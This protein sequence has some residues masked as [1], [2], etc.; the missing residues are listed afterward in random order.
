MTIIV[1][2]RWQGSFTHQ[3]YSFYFVREVHKW[4]KQTTFGQKKKERYKKPLRVPGY[5]KG[6][7]NSF[8]NLFFFHA[9]FSFFPEFEDLQ[10]QLTPELAGA[11]VA[12][13][14][15]ATRLRV[16]GANNS[17]PH[18][19]RNKDNAPGAVSTLFL[20]LYFFSCVPPLTWLRHRRRPCAAVSEPRVHEEK[21]SDSSF[22][23]LGDLGDLGKS[24][25]CVRFAATDSGTGGPGPTAGCECGVTGLA[26]YKTESGRGTSCAK[27]RFTRNKDE[28]NAENTTTSHPAERCPRKVAFIPPRSKR[29]TTQKHT[30]KKE[31]KQGQ[32]GTGENQ[33]N[34]NKERD[35]R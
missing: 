30:K 24:A 28:P 10:L 2:Q 9:S 19:S 16:T 1:Q 14:A 34:G 3:N 4:N 12:E 26:G 11:E 15:N 13:I 32:K 18:I 5:L 17:P 35:G 22:A 8:L 31:I 6:Y 7:S 33:R 23:Y 25:A 21:L 27:P 20:L 29:K